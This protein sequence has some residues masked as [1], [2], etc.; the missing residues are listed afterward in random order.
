M[1]GNPRTRMTGPKNRRSKLG[2]NGQLGSLSDPSDDLGQPGASESLYSRGLSR[3]RLVR[4]AASARVP[5]RCAGKSGRPRRTTRVRH[6]HSFPPIH[7]QVPLQ[8]Q[9]GEARA[10][11]RS[12]G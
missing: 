12:L 11:S 2:V 7:Q 4:A 8:A 1:A 3:V 10:F 9:A 5:C 6:A